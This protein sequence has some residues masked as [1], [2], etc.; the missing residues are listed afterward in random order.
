MR[1]F[2]RLILFILPVSLFLQCNSVKQNMPQDHTNALINET[3]PYLLQHAHNPVNWYPWGEEALKKAKDENKLLIISIGYSSCHW[4]HV[5][6][7]ESFEDSTVA[8]LMNEHF[9]SI[10]I[11][12]EERPDLD[13]LYMGAVQLMTGRGGWPLNCVALPDGRPIWGGTYFPKDQWMKSLETVHEIYTTEPQRVID[14]A[15]DLED[16]IKKSDNIA[17]VAAV[18]NFEEADLQ[19]MVQNWKRR[20]DQRLGGPDEAP[21]FPLPNNY[22]F[23]LRY[24]I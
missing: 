6:E 14:Y 1:S 3:S 21:K 23:L 4:C 22:Q 19:D 15:D 12:R 17:P 18:P 20:F 13:N 9:I 8:A 7:H 2:L 11:D 5:M 24:G 10:K 16:G